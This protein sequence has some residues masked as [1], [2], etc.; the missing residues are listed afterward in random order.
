ML[1]GRNCQ[2][3]C[4]EWTSPWVEEASRRAEGKAGDEEQENKVWTETAAFLKEELF[5]R[6]GLW[7]RWLWCGGQEEQWINRSAVGKTQTTSICNNRNS[8]TDMERERCEDTPH[9]QR[10]QAVSPSGSQKT[11]P[12]P[13]D[14]GC[15]A[16]RTRGSIC[17]LFP[18]VCGAGAE[19]PPS[20]IMTAQL[21]CWLG[22]ACV[23][24]SI[25]AG[26]D[27][28]LTPRRDFGTSVLRGECRESPCN[29]STGCFFPDYTDECGF[30][31]YCF[32]KIA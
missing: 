11:Q 14:F 27:S 3:G 1:L 25:K 18:P 21:S 6:Q 31:I 7:P 9:I 17:N 13:F 24:S 30:G 19:E 23:I 4:E 15:P 2:S 12:S 32:R 8:D 20:W 28:R 29:T 16:C 5:S 10:P 22:D 26:R